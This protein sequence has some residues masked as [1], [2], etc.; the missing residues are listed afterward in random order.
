[1]D[2]K[3]EISNGFAVIKV[4]DNGNGIAAE[5][6]DKLFQ[7]NFTTKSGGMGMGLAIVKSIVENTNGGISYETTIGKGTT[8]IVRLPL[9]N[10]NGERNNG[11]ME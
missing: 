7:P 5:L 9:F 10:K 3:L 6:G 8:F 2:I 4:K 11:I 1:V